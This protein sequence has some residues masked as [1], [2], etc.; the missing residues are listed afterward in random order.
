MAQTKAFQKLIHSDAME[1]IRNLSVPVEGLAEVIQDH[2][3]FDLYSRKPGPAY[4][5]DGVIKP[6]DLDLV[7]F[8]SALADRN[9]VINLPSYTSKRAKTIREG[10]TVISNKNRHGKVIGLNANK[11]VLSFSI[12]IEDMNVMSSDGLGSEEIGA[13]RNFMIVDLDG[14]FYSGWKTI[15]FV[16]TAKENDFL[17][18]KQLWTGNSIYFEN[19]VHPMRWTSFFGQYFFVTKALI[20]RLEQ[21]LT[22]TNL[23]IQQL[24]KNGIKFPTS[25]DGSKKEWPAS[26]KGESKSISVKTCEVEVDIPWTGSYVHP[27]KIENSQENLVRLDKLAHKIKHKQLPALRFATRATELAFFKNGGVT[28]NFPTWIKGASWETDYV[29]PGKRTEW[30]RLMLTQRF[31]FEKGFAIRYREF[32]K[33]ER[34]AV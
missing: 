27:S 33:S 6:T 9:A 14:E 17:N 1:A 26:T 29:Q 30:N 3:T 20:N 8:L 15:E 11:A 18:D 21:D 34:V 32:E 24:L 2:W 10:E 22:Y 19:F 28:T 4:L 12:R 13:P 5:E 31:P 7:C 16:P 25:G 23:C